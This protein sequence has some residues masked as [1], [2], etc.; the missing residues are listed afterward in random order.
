MTSDDETHYEVLGV[1]PTASKEAIR[2]A[3]QERIDAARADQ[4]R[5]QEGKKPDDAALSSARSDEARFAPPGR[6]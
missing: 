4:T 6:S 5:A 3:Y 1:D 2:A